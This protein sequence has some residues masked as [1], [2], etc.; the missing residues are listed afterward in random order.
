M[1]GSDKVWCV[2]SPHPGSRGW[3]HY[4][5]L[6][7]QPPG[8]SAVKESACNAGDPSLIPGSGRSPGE[9]IR[10]PLQYYWAS[11]VS[12][13]VKNP[14]AMQETWVPS[15]GWEDPLEE[16]IATHSSIPAWRIPWAEEPGGL[17]SVESQRVRHDWVTFTFTFCVHRQ[18]K[19]K[20][21]GHS[22]PNIV[23]VIYRHLLY[24]LD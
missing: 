14:P 10:Y 1:Q 3:T 8:G 15:V 7:A 20:E 18:D 17:Q 19:E 24:K 6:V 23:G 2:S 16:G 13:T 21:E 9:G 22:F 11:L 4:H 12:Q 5:H